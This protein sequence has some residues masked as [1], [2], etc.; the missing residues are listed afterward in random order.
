MAMANTTHLTAKVLLVQ[1]APPAK[2]ARQA[3][4]ALSVQRATQARKV[5][6]AQTVPMAKTARRVRLVQPAHR[7]LLASA[8]GIPMAMVRRTKTR[9]STATAM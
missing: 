7:A 2:M 6:L 5:R 4:K 9:M 1:R 3:R 8:A